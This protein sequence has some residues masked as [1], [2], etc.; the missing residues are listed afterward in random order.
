VLFTKLK[1][2]SAGKDSFCVVYKIK[3]PSAGKD[4]FSMVYEIKTNSQ[5]LSICSV[6][7]KKSKPSASR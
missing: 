7:F 2:P 3:T 4:S 5:L 6:L 1:P